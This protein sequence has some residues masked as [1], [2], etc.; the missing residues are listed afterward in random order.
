MRGCRRLPGRERVST[1]SRLAQA[2]VLLGNSPLLQLPQNASRRVPLVG[3]CQSPS[4]HPSATNVARFSSVV[5]VRSSGI[6]KGRDPS[7]RVA[8]S[9]T[10]SGC[11]G[12]GCLQ[13]LREWLSPG[14]FAQPSCCVASPVKEG[15]RPGLLLLRLPMRTEWR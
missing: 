12:R 2:G 1:C 11:P 9:D 14:S 6:G 8:G 5:R 4:I 13:G 15:V 7:N 10:N 3:L